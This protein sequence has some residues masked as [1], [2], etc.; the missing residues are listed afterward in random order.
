MINHEIQFER[1][2]QAY[3]KLYEEYY[4]FKNHPTKQNKDKL[5]KVMQKFNDTKSNFSASIRN[6]FVK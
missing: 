1:M 2:D 3:E 6:L 5:L 4:C